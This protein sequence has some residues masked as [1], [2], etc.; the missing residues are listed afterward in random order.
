MLKSNYLATTDVRTFIDWLTPRI[1]GDDPI[2]FS[3]PRPNGATYQYLHNAIYS[4]PPRHT[5]FNFPTG[6]V[7]NLAA[8]ASLAANTAVL[9]HISAGLTATLAVGNNIDF[10]KWAKCLMKWGGVESGNNSWIDLNRQ[11]ICHIANGVNGAVAL[12]DDSSAPLEPH[13]R[14]NSGMTK[15]YSLLNPN[16]IIYD[17]RVAAALAW[18]VYSWSTV[19]PQE[20][21]FRCMPARKTIQQKIRNP[22]TN[23]FCWVNSD[24]YQ[25]IKWNIRA[26]WILE[27]AYVRAVAQCPHIKFHDLREVEASLFMLG[28]DL[29]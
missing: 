16:F 15:L 29:P 18:L 20:L 9:N 14:F 5:E 23:Q 7:V 13:L 2:G 17:S 21:A 25:H 10:A 26:N 8:N 1:G 27:D 28:A 24:P 11:R 19:V 22:D 12:G 4:W 6:A 3:N